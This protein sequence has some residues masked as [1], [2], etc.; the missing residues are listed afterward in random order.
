MR[1]VAC[2]V[3]PVCHVG[4]ARRNSIVPAV[5]GGNTG[6]PATMIGNMVSATIL[7]DAPPP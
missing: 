6:A 1:P 3:V 7:E 5:V 2:V 4:T